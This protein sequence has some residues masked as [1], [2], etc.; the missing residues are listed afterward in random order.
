MSEAQD[1]RTCFTEPPQCTINCHLWV[2]SF[3]ILLNS[4]NLMNLSEICVESNEV[5]VITGNE[6]IE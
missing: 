5:L 6:I 3:K 2:F 4:L 1:R